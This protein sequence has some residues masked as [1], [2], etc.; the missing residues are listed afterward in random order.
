MRNNIKNNH[1]FLLESEAIGIIRKAIFSFK[2]PVML[3]SGG[4]D[5]LVML[6]LAYLACYPNKIPFQIL[7]IDTGHNFPETITFRDEVA[8][9]Y[10]VELLVGSVENTIAEGK[11]ID[12]TGPGATRNGIQSITLM[13][14]IHQ[15]QFD[16]VFGGGRRD[17]EKARAKERIFSY[18]N[19]YGKWE[20][21]NQQPELWNLFNLNTNDNSHYRCFP[22]S[23]WTEMD[24]WQYIEAE[25][26]T[27][28]S[29]YFSHKR[30]V[31]ERGGMWL[32]NHPFIY[33][34]IKE[35]ATIETI[36]FRTLGDVTCSGAIASTASTV[37]DIIAELQ[38]L[39]ISERGG[40]ADDKLSEA[41]MEN[42][43]KQGY[44]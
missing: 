22:I 34:Q 24:V 7:H 42:R 16:C 41:A 1:L 12:E 38:H 27:L 31:I 28:P 4:K 18:R 2:N 26:L 29:L 43:K 3:F 44:F 23:N 33:P 8:A 10:N 14:T 11:A 36:R 30:S 25:Q 20:A 37:S 39:R 21:E 5:S 32:A 13:D 17:E 40:R 35:I 19:Y 6:H 9:F 15:Y